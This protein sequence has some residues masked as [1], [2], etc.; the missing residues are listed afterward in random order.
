MNDSKEEESS[1]KILVGQKI[2]AEVVIVPGDVRSST[3]R[4]KRSTASKLILDGKEPVKK[5]LIVLAI[6]DTHFVC[7]YTSTFGGSS[8]KLD[9]ERV[10]NAHNWYP[11]AP[12]E[13]EH[14]P[15]A[16]PTGGDGVAGWVCLSQLISVPLEDK[17]AVPL[18]VFYPEASV[19]NI[20]EKFGM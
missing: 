20:K 7:A 5:Q 9:P 13:G 8:S 12:A 4:S 14:T 2:W 6:T 17:T 1:P 16:Q 19:D 18:P 11:I 10:V 3:S 15:L